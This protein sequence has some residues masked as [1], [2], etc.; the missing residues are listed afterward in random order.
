MLLNLN[1]KRLIFDKNLSL[2]MLVLKKNNEISFE[3]WHSFIN[4]LS[5]S[6]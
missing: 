4:I 3:D 2:K 1:F 6:T 5:F